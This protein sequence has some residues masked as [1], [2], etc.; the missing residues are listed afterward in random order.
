MTRKTGALSNIPAPVLRYGLACVS[1]AIALGTALLLEHDRF[2][3]V[4]DPLFLF[5]IAISVWYGGR[6]PGVFA[7]VLSILAND[8]FF[9]L[10]IHSL[11]V[12]REDIPH[13]LV[14]IV[15]ASLLTWFAAIRR[16]IEQNL[17]ESRDHLQAEVALRTRQASLL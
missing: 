11:Y 15:F 9:T 14:F 16:R 12:T 13:I 6:G 5:A 10:P 3:D 2:Q 17:L 1:V 7:V 8:Y 4:A